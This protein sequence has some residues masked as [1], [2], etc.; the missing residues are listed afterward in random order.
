GDIKGL[1]VDFY[2]CRWVLSY[3]KKEIN[4][5]EYY[6]KRPTKGWSLSKSQFL[7]NVKIAYGMYGLSDI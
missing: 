4:L 7:N 2:S 1:T 5:T 6:K 3:L